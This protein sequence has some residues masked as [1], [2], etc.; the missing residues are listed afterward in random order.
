MRKLIFQEIKYNKKTDFCCQTMSIF[1]QDLRIGIDYYNVYREYY[2]DTTADLKQMIY[3][4]PFCGKELPKGLGEKYFD[5][6]EK[7]Y[8]IEDIIEEEENIP[9]EFKTDEWWKKRGL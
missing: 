4:C 1:V 7:D 9:E 2:I 6:L 3:Y 8:Q 5:I